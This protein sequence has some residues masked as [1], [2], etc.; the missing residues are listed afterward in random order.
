MRP[1]DFVSIIFSPRD[2]E[3]GRGFKLSAT[4]RKSCNIVTSWQQYS[5]RLF[6]GNYPDILKEHQILIES[7]FSQLGL[8]VVQMLSC[9]VLVVIFLDCF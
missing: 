6:Q 9:S 2:V 1:E 5:K 7:M 8:Y 3:Q 4:S